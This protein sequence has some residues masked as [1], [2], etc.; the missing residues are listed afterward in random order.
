M[1]ISVSLVGNKEI[2]TLNK[3][4]LG[5]DCA[6]DVLSFNYSESDADKA[7]FLGDVVVSTEK[8]KE[9][10]PD[11][12]NTYEQEIADLVAHG[13]LHLLGVHHGDSDAVST[14]RVKRS[15]GLK[16]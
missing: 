5:R 3:R 13:V 2:R 1:H 10:A 11:Y 8:A 14:H 9:Q 12:G 4:Y 7:Q 6:T 16:I 15:K